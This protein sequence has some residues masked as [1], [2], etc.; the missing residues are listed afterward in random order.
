M[1]A[2]SRSG[3]GWVVAQFGLIGAIAASTRVPLRF[4][5]PVRAAG[6]PLA[7]AGAGLGVAA[8]R[9]LGGSLTPFPEPRP[10]GEL[11][12]DG[13]YGVV[14]HPIYAGGTLFFVGVSL[15]A[16]PVTLALTAALAAL[17]S[18]KAREEERRLE[19]RFP[20]Y[21]DYARRTPRGLP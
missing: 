3:S 18:L 5:R 19:R 9:R 14:R 16:G 13:P 10:D 11:V 12:E 20:A 15:L 4:A 7:A 2:S 21:A 8:A 1:S 6:I 17:W